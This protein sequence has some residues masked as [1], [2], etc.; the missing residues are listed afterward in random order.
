MI[1]S[2]AATTD[3]RPVPPTTF[4]L[5]ARATSSL[6]PAR[7]W[8]P[9][10]GSVR[11]GVA[12][13]RDFT[14]CAGLPPAGAASFVGTP[15]RGSP[16]DA[17]ESGVLHTPS[18][19]QRLAKARFS[20][21]NRR[22]SVYIACVR[23]ATASADDPGVTRRNRSSRLQFTRVWLD[24]SPHRS[25]LE[26][27]RSSS[28]FPRSP[29]SIP[30][31]PRFPP[32]VGSLSC[33]QSVGPA[34]GI[35]LIS[36]FRLRRR[37]GR[38]RCS[39]RASTLTHPY[40]RC[41]ILFRARASSTEATKPRRPGRPS[42]SVRSSHHVTEAR[43]TAG[44]RRVSLGLALPVAP[45]A[46]VLPIRVAVCS[47]PPTVRNLVLTSRSD[48]LNPGL[49]RGR[50]PERPTATSAR[51]SCLSAL[52]GVLRPYAGV[53]AQGPEAIAVQGRRSEPA[54]RTAGAGNDGRA[55]PTFRLVRPAL[56]RT[57]AIAVGRD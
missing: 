8:H 24:G 49:D 17:D 16:R 50:R 9:T 22:T 28:T 26:P 40:L 32:R 13:G 10:V 27:Y 3:R 19:A 38:L 25:I 37:G 5:D 20:R 41:R 43:R 18:V 34:R 54:R 36:T 4:P 21:L 33:D 47:L 31:P 11:T 7:L 39:T 15:E 56:L 42:G 52:I 12:L 55:G 1:A 35:G 2:Q 29:S 48:Q 46:T 53:F 14:G 30:S 51:R 44:R 45:G 57:S 23:G 6:G